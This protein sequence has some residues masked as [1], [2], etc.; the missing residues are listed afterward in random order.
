[1]QTMRSKKW[2]VGA[3][4]L[5]STCLSGCASASVPGHPA[6]A[7]TASPSPAPVALTCDDLLPVDVAAAALGLPASTL[8]AWEFDNTEGT[9]GTRGAVVGAMSGAAR[10]A[11]DLVECRWS[12]EPVHSEKSP[13]VRI[14]ILPGAA[15]EFSLVVPDVNDG[16]TAFEP[17]AV[18]DTGYVACHGG[19]GQGCRVEALTG[20]NWLSLSV[21]PDFDDP[22]TA[23]DLATSLVE[24][25]KGMPTGEKKPPAVNCD[26]L[27]TVESLQNAGI[28]DATQ[29]TTDALGHRDSIW[30]AALHRAGYR[31]CGWTPADSSEPGIVSVSALSLAESPSAAS[32]TGGATSSVPFEPVLGLGDSA[33]ASCTDDYC[34]LVVIGSGT[35]LHFST[36]DPQ[37]TDAE[38]L[39]ALAREA[40]ISLAS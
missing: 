35:W 1:M 11:S 39:A 36:V 5:A 7:V 37:T 16:L 2:L 4:L 10:A 20:Q 38:A 14:S 30:I 33:A 32:P 34:E 40:L 23:L 27:L 28:A 24:R 22:A 31:S 3:A 18:G 21:S 19:E 26:S 17:A 13:A 15:E 25:V 6:I 29:Y 9:D 12:A 8:V